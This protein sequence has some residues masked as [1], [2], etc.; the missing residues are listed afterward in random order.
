MCLP[1]SCFFFFSSH[2]VPPTNLRLTASDPI[3]IDEAG[4][5]SVNVFEDS[6]TSFAC[7]SVGSRPK[8]VISWII[9]SDDDLGST[10]STST[11]N[12][13]DQGLRDTKSN[14]QLIPKR[15]HHNQLL[16]CVAYAGMNQRQTKVRV[17]VYGEYSYFVFTIRHLL[18]STTYKRPNAV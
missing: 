16:R 3:T 17:I 4:T 1:I 12:Q 7:K 15:R 11:I 8:A 13:A 18:D 10:T 14:L 5:R 9:G 6:A 2:L